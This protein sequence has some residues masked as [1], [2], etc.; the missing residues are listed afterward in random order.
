[1]ACIA[2]LISAVILVVSGCSKK[3]DTGI[4]QKTDGAEMGSFINDAAASVAPSNGADGKTDEMDNNDLL[5]K[6]IMDNIYGYQGEYE[7][8]KESYTNPIDSIHEDA[9]YDYG[10]GDPF[11]MRYNGYYYLYMSTRDNEVGIKCFS[12][13]DLV[14]WHYEGLCAD[15]DVTKG[16]YAPEVTYYNGKFYMY[17]SPAGNGHYVFE[18]DS[19]MG[20]FKVI[21]HN[22]GFSIDGSVFIDDDGKWYFYHAGDKGIVAHEMTSPSDIEAGGKTVGA[23]MNGWTEGSMVIKHDGRYYITY[24]GNHVLSKGYR[25]DYGVGDSPTDFTA[26]DT[27]PLLLHTMSEPYG[28]GHSSSVKGPDLDSYYIVYH[29]L[30]GRAMEGMPK[31]EMNIDRIVFDGDEMDVLGPTMSEQPIPSMPDIY[32]YFNG[33]A[34]DE[35]SPNNGNDSENVEMIINGSSEDAW[36]ISDSLI[37]TRDEHEADFTAEYNI[38]MRSGAESAVY[39][40]YTDEDNYGSLTVS[41]EDQTVAVTI[42]KDGVK[43][44]D[45]FELKG[46]FGEEV[47]LTSNQAFQVEVSDGRGQVYMNDRLLGEFDCPLGGGHIAVS[48]GEARVNYGFVGVSNAV[49]GSSA[50]DYPK[51]LPGTIHASHASYVDEKGAEYRVNLAE[52]GSYDM[53]VSYSSDK[54]MM[55]TLYIDGEP[56][57]GHELLL[58]ACNEEAQAK[59]AILRGIELPEGLHDIRLGYDAGNAEDA[60][61]SLGDISFGKHEDVSA[62]T[63]SYDSILDESVYSD[64]GWKIADGTMSVRAGSAAAKRLYGSE[65]MGDY[66]FKCRMSIDGDKGSAGVLFRASD[67]ALGG[68]GDDSLLGTAFVRGYYLD[69]WKGKVYLQKLNYGQKSLAEAD[70]ISPGQDGV[71]DIEVKL[72]A[73]LIEISVNGDK[74]IS[75]IDNDRPFMNGMAGIRSLGASPVVEELSISPN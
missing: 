21:T 18:S 70:I 58:E 31:R 32:G 38:C 61:F 60:A 16:A 53:T 1:M 52:K 13:R 12:S 26:A 64:G 73:N 4:S 45:I 74:L 7:D 15:E 11:V 65:Y 75:Y 5:N 22:L 51:P 71:Y 24:T 49:K 41:E 35:S 14:N 19:P 63:V 23:Y 33:K 36:R 72:T 46:S 69:I 9:W 67:P 40:S 42:A 62:L 29:T 27:N 66:S 48:G 56:L 28:I 2:V 10:T 44:A 54:D 43:V 25:I 8:M 68:P 57:T 55:L 39:F 37:I 6:N 50:N 3:P 47:M 59:Y 20:P 17:S 30:V 34:D